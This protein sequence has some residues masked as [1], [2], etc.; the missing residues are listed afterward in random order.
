M[1]QGTY[2]TKVFAVSMTFEL[3]QDAFLCHARVQ[4][5]RD[6]P[7]Y[8]HSELSHIQ[9]CVAAMQTHLFTC[10]PTALLAGLPTQ[11]Q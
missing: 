5:R 6:Q 9:M 2:K 3:H 1:Q 8:K 7:V 10:S 4:G 11:D